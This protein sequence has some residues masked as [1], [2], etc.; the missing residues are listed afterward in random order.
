MHFPSSIKPRYQTNTAFRNIELFSRDALDLITLNLHPW[1]K[2]S[3]LQ[4]LVTRRGA[5][6][7]HTRAARDNL[8]AL[9]AMTNPYLPIR[10]TVTTP[11][12][13]KPRMA[14]SIPT[15]LPLLTS[16]TTRRKT[17]HKYTCLR[18]IVYSQQ[19]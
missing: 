14:T 12:Q 15:I 9:L 6:A 10:S 2:S 3:L 5:I 13:L 17:S 18:T 16:H 19:Q 1:P 11:A 8:T 7:L 4:C